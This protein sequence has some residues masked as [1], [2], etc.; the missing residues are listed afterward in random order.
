MPR[1][2]RSFFVVCMMLPALA[3]AE[4]QIRE[5][6]PGE[7][8]PAKRHDTVTV[9]YTGWLEDG[10]KFDSSRDRNSPFSLVL[11]QGQVIP[12]WERGL[13][14]MQA[15]GQRELIIPPELGYGPRGAGGV[16]PPNATL[17]FE[18][19][20]LSITPPPFSNL[21]HQALAARLQAGD[22]KVIDIRRA[23]E[24]Q[25]TGVIPGSH[26]LTAF[27]E[28]GHLV[29]SF[30]QDIQ[31]LVKPDEP[32]VIVCR[33]GNRTGVLSRALAEQ[34]GYSK[35]HNLEEGITDWISQGQAVR[36]DCPAFAH[37]AQC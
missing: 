17:R 15:G 18:V 29:P 3:V 21:D 33:V 10:T 31:A 22:I 35:V 20:L 23:D 37:G 4:V 36:K 7:G 16:I 2:I 27:D 6:H 13:L 11:G 1:G 12:G 34:A 8:P 9:H 14:G 26:L 19:E 32:F 30:P 24:W 25:A 28:R 5:L